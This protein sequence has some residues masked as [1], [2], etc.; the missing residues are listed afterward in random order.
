MSR[1]GLTL[2]QAMPGELP[3]GERVL[4]C[5]GPDATALTRY[6]MHTRKVAV[7][8]ALL[9]VWRQV[10]IWQSGLGFDAALTSARTTLL[11]AAL[12]IGILMLYGR[13]AARQTLYTI[14]NRRVVI[15]S[16]VALSIAVN[17]PFSKIERVDVKR[18]EDGGGDIALTL[19]RDARAGYAVLWP[20]ARPLR[21]LRP[22]PLLRAL[23]DVDPV[24]K[25]LGEALQQD[26][27]AAEHSAA[28]DAANGEALAAS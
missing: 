24:A 19:A 2:A 28:H 8:F 3:R 22:V 11:L 18:R 7:Y 16:G 15:R 26:N 14:T 20:S 21:I 1:A 5:G 4:W 6:A 12:A 25:V 13:S 17:L 27:Q 23:A 10:G 9:L